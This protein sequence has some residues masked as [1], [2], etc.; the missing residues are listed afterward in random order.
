MFRRRRPIPL[1]QRLRQAL[2]PERGWGRAGNYLLKRIKR[3]PG[4]PHS[5]AAGFA[6]GVFISF[7]PF[8]GFHLIGSA[9]LAL[10]VRGNYIAAWVG[11]LVGNPWT[12]PFIWVLIYQLGVFILG[13]EAAMRTPSEVDA[14]TIAWMTGNFERLIWPMTVGGIPAGLVAGLACYFPMVRALAAF[15]EARRRRRER[16]RQKREGRLGIKATDP[17]TGAA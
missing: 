5:I 14:W 10:L 15:Q 3:L 2:W 16:H 12:F 11:T 8:I 9:L 7:T 1:L 4:S 13:P 6:S 17:S